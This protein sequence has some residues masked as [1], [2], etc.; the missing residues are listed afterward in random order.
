MILFRVIYLSIQ[1]FFLQIEKGS[2]P[3]HEVLG[4]WDQEMAVRNEY[5]KK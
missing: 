4:F 3:R 2:S 1:G 5:L